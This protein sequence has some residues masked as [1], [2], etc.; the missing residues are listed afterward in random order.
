[1][2]AGEPSLLTTGQAAKLC[3]VT[4]DTILKWIRKGRLSGVRTAGGHYRIERRDLEP[5]MAPR[6]PA[7]ATANRLSE[8]DRQRLR[9]WE[10]LS[11]RGTV[12]DECQ[13][14]VV[15]RVRAA[16]CFL[17]A[18]MEQDVGHVRQFCQT[19]CEDCVCYRQAQGLATTVLVIS[20]DDDFVKVLDGH[21]SEGIAL[22]FAADAYQASAIIHDFRP[23]FAVV[24]VEPTPGGEARLLESLATDRRVPGLRIVAVVPRRMAGRKRRLAKM[25]SVIGVLEKPLGG[26]EVAEVIDDFLV[27]F[28]RAG[29]GS[30]WT[31]VHPRERR[32]TDKC[33]SQSRGSITSTS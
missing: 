33:P 15:Y 9:C 28:T 18:G 32:L 7:D 22:R 16:R 14:C 20:K 11:D 27:N 2:P 12:R 19:S 26:H 29:D 30:P 3:S 31:P 8:C 21:Q 25:D 23:A 4:P 24:D 10:Y 17:M 1:M 13:Q 5:L 6:R